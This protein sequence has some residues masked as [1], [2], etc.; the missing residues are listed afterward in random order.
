MEV[1]TLPKLLELARAEI[2]RRFYSIRT[3]QAYLYWIKQFI[4]FHNKR[5]PSEVGH[6]GVTEFLSHLVIHKD[7]AA[8]TQNQAFSAIL[9]L[10]RDVLKQPL[11]P[12]DGV[13][14][15]K[16][17]EKLPVVFSRQEISAIL[18][19]LEASKW[20][21][22][23]LL[24]GS[25]L[26]LMECLRLRVKDLDFDYAQIVV[27]DGKGAKDRVTVLPATLRGPLQGHLVRVRA[28]HEQDLKSGYGRV[29]L[30]H[31]L[32]RKYSNAS[33]EWC[34][35]YVFPSA[36]MSVDPRSGARRRHHVAETAIQ[37]AVSMAI[38]RAGVS[39]PGS[40]HTFRHSFATHLLEAGYD[41]RTVQELLGHKEV[42]TTLIYTHVLNKGGKGVKSPLE[43]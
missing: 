29:Y 33:R 13:E 27:R 20:L 18:A 35:Q 37:K 42:C 11:Q 5:H 8:S 17:P 16:R 24:Y 14:R 3:E 19:Q 12:L 23:S 2:R 1:D 7:V 6:G 38:R 15:A 43:L 28:L 22:A 10:Y 9:F 25:G 30:P 39:K 4:L 31:A 32:A 41:I 26:R 34:W 21:I 40:C 36:R